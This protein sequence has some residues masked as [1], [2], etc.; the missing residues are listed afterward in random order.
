MLS[1]LSKDICSPL[2]LL[3]FGERS[4]PPC[5]DEKAV[6]VGEVAVVLKAI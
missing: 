2:G 3:S 6:G 5:L 1:F 4:D